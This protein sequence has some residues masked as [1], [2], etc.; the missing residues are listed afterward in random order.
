MQQSI[1]SF[2]SLAKSWVNPQKLHN[3]NIYDWFAIFSERS[4]LPLDH[5]PFLV[6]TTY[7]ID[8]LVQDYSISIANALEILQSY[9]NSLRP[10]DAYMRQ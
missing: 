5:T 4:W 8:G 2:R 9:I 1:T 10:S 6:A 3:K 7:D